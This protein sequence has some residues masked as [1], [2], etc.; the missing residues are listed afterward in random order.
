[1]TTTEGA[2]DPDATLDLPDAGAASA[3]GLRLTC[4]GEVVITGEEIGRG[5]MGRVIAARAER[6]A[7]PVAVK[8]SLADGG[9]PRRRFEREAAV[10]AR[11]Q[12]PAIVPVYGAGHTE[13]GRP[14][15]VMKR[16]AGRRLDEAIAGA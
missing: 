2:V 6:L 4:D 14:F 10:T 11:L 5:G 13:A 15:Y 1:M 16:V 3:A 12:H 7:R 9:E 8:E